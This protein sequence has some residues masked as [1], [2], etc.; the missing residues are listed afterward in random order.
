[1][2][3]S[4]QLSLEL[5]DLL[6]ETTVLMG[7]MAD[8]VLETGET[9]GHQGRLRG[10]SAQPL[11]LSPLALLHLFSLI[12]P[13]SPLRGK[14]GGVRSGRVWPRASQNIFLSKF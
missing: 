5:A 3:F 2:S 1:M 9:G 8:L 14:L 13:R 6:E 11:V 10:R 4:L 12:A 7:E